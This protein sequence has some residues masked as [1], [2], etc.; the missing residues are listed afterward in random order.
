MRTLVVGGTGFIGETLCRE[1]D[2]RGDDVT[3]FSVHRDGTEHVVR[4]AEA[5]GVD[6]LL[7]MSALGADPDGDTAYLEAKGLAEAA[8]RDSELSWTIFRPSVVF[9]DGGEFLP[10]TRRL[11]PP[12][13]T[14]LPGGGETRFQ[15]I[16]VGDLVPMLADALA[17]DAPAT[18]RETTGAGDAATA[19]LDGDLEPAVTP[20]GDVADAAGEDPHAGR[21]YDLGGPAVVT[22]AEVAA[23]AHAANGK[24]VDVVP[25]PMPVA[26]VGLASLDLLPPG[27]LDAVPGVPRMGSDQYRSLQI[28]N[29]VA[30]N[31]VTAFGVEP[32][33]LNSVPAYLDVDPDAVEQ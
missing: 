25:I 3:H 11:A 29:T 15:P 5:H 23:L 14:P 4:A 1:L 19:R 2:R 9:G 27:V 32:P 20:V 30:D 33:E 16:W 28:D 8:V 21:T 10:Y 17:G 31:D 26:K 12:Y 22:L 7:Q 18:D 6:R 13:L 24:P